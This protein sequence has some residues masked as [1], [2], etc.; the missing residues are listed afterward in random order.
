MSD[1]ETL[2]YEQAV[3]LVKLAGWTVDLWQSR[4]AQRPWYADV[5]DPEGD[6]ILNCMPCLTQTAARQALIEWVKGGMET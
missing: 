1:D 2:T 5:L 4:G 6:I 3:A